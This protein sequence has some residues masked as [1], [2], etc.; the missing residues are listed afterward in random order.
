MNVVPAS[1]AGRNPIGWRARIGIAVP[2]TNTVCEAECNRMAPAGVSFHFI[3]TPIHRGSDAGDPVPRIL[4]DAERAAADLFA[5]RVSAIAYACTSSSMACP[6]DKLIGTIERASKAKAIS[7][8]GAILDALRALGLK[9]IAMASPYLQETNEHEAEFL[10]DH[11]V[12]VVAMA[13]L[14][15]NTP[16]HVGEMSRVPPAKVFELAQSV[17]RPEAEGI[18]ICC[19]DFNTADVIAPL[20]A[21][22]NKPVISSISATLWRVLRRA[23]I[24]DRI[25]GYGRLLMTP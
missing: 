6:A 17:D 16:E 20:E 13:G 15:L 19:T 11:G 8:A 5:T 21:A 18:L 24:D 3:R 22:L 14:G 2:M 12:T 7:T 9:K 25:P 23:G 1:L 4:A 10:A